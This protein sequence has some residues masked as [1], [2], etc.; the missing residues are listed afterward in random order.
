M[1]REWIKELFGVNKPII[2]MCH[3]EALPGDPGYNVD[4]GLEWVI[5]RAYR[6]LQALQE[7]GVDA[8]MFSNEASLPYLTKVEPITPIT[9]ARIIGELRR[10]IKVPFGVNVLWDPLA[11]IDLAVATGAAFVREVFTGVYASD[12]GLWN[13]NCGEVVRHQYRLHGK[14][15]KLFFNIVPEAASYLGNRDIKDI[16]RSTVFNTRPDALCVSGLTA[17]AE[18]DMQTLKLVKQA[19]PDMAVFANTGVRLENVEQQLSIA[20]GAIVGTAFKRDGYIW[21]EVDVSRVKVFME[22]VREVRDS[23]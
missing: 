11:T 21:N 10:Y 17:G 14:N 23:L 12:F 6:D 3:L 16:A 9:M 19:V 20:D 15:I 2:A 1:S 8:I 13:T 22:K 7:G 5:E 4:K 18:T